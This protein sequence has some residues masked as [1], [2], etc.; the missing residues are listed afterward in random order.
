M[1]EKEKQGKHIFV[2]S[3]ALVSMILTGPLG[4]RIWKSQR[5]DLLITRRCNSN[6]GS[7]DYRRAMHKSLYVVCFALVADASVPNSP[8]LGVHDSITSWYRSS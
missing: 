5:E 6:V 8:E 4:R 1:Q 2:T 3:Y 7:A